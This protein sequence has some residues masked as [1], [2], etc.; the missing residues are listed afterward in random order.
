MPVPIKQV[1]MLSSMAVIHCLEQTGL[2]QL[3]ATS[4]IRLNIFRWMRRALLLS[5]F[6]LSI[7]AINSGRVVVECAGLSRS[8]EEGLASSPARL[9]SAVQVE[10]G[11]HAF[12]A[13][14]RVDVL[15]QRDLI[16]CCTA[17]ARRDSAVS[18]EVLPYL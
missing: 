11:W 6:R 10:L 12:N 5:D 18:E 9:Q 4:L 1:A 2:G 16:A 3:M 13:M 17:L 14:C 8:R 7:V 15:H